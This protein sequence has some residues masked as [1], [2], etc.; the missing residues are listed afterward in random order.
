MHYPAFLGAGA[1]LP[2]F[3]QLIQFCEV[4]L[5]FLQTVICCPPKTDLQF[6]LCI[7]FPTSLPSTASIGTGGWWAELEAE[8]RAVAS[9]PLQALQYMGVTLAS[10]P[11]LHFGG[12]RISLI[13]W[14]FFL[15]WLP[16]GSSTSYSSLSFQLF[17]LVYLL[18]AC[19]VYGFYC[20]PFLGQISFYFFFFFM[21]F[22][23][24]AC[25]TSQV[26]LEG[27]F[28]IALFSF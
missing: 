11:S 4:F 19:C 18:S 17:L 13:P 27:I 2:P 12:H 21:L 15:P 5:G 26:R 3:F 6:L 14:A 25:T 9:R 10:V 20:F 1:H 8:H 23:V 28:W 22:C 7:C 16:L 24:I